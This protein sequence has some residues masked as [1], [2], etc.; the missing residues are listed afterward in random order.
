MRVKLTEGYI[1]E[2]T[3]REKERDE[4]ERRIDAS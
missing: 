3:V 4:N 1:S 2:D